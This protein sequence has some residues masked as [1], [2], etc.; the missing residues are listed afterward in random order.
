M[1]D[2]VFSCICPWSLCFSHCWMLVVPQTHEAFSMSGLTCY[3]LKLEHCPKTSHGSSVKSSLKDLLLREVFLSSIPLDYFIFF[4]DL[5]IFEIA[6]FFYCYLF[7]AVKWKIHRICLN[8]CP[9]CLLVHCTHDLDKHITWLNKQNT[10]W[11]WLLVTRQD[12]F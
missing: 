4:M 7:A 10:S 6:V 9:P 1:S 8:F 5:L 12:I 11:V 3:I 2:L